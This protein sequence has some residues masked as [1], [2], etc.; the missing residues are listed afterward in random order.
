MFTNSVCSYP[1]RGPFGNNQYRGN[2]SGYIVKDLI[3]SY[4]PAGGLFIDPSVGGGTS[5]DVAKSLNV[6]FKGFDLHSG[7]NLL[8]DDLA[9]TAGGLADLIFYHPPYADMIK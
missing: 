1:S 5:T 3:G 6:N 8:V 4:L 7:F 2:C 9:Q